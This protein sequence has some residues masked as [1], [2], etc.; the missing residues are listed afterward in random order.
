MRALFRTRGTGIDCEGA[1]I[2]F[3]AR[4]E[5]SGEI[6]PL[7]TALPDTV[8]FV[9]SGD[10]DNASLVRLM[11]SEIERRRCGAEAV[12]RRLGEVLVVR[13]MR[14]QIET[15]ARQPGLLAGLSDPRLSR[16]IVAIH[17]RPGRARRNA[18][19]AQVAGMSLS[20]FAET[21]LAEV[22][23]PP[24]AY[25]RR[26][27]LT[28]AWQDV[29]KGLRVDTVSGRYGFSS[30]E[31]FTRAFKKHYGKTPMEMRQASA[32]QQRGVVGL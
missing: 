18:E 16:A 27:R 1:Q 8:D 2:L 12:L 22:G 19:L 10:S 28:L 14:S 3:G 29:V 25:L 13:M 30:P 20:R 17:D 32:S 5:W 11:Q 24:G 21:F 26:W 4:V 9:L 31:G 6:N 23:E 15:G 7:L